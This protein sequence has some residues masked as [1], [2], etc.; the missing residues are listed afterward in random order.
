M[1]LS[2][3]RASAKFPTLI[4]LSLIQYRTP[5]LCITLNVALTQD[6]SH[7]NMPDSFHQ[8]PWKI[9]KNVNKKKKKKSIQSCNVE[10]SETELSVY[11]DPDQKLI[12]SILGRDAPF[13][14]IWWKPVQ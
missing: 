6:T 12:E 8:D 4:Q 5:Y 13:I 9:S 10:D 7:L 11:L 1:A 14:Q 2:R 3:A